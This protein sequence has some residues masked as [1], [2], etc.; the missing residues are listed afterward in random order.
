M[1]LKD[2]NW[3]AYHGTTLDKSRTC[4]IFTLSFPSSY[5]NVYPIYDYFFLKHLFHRSTLTTKN[6]GMKFLWL[7]QKIQRVDY[8][9]LYVFCM[10]TEF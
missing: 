1:D 5:D 10:Y 9:N 4:W 3:T 7:L 8:L 6:Q 2:P